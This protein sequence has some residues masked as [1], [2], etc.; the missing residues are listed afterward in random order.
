MLCE[1]AL[2]A[3]SACLTVAAPSTAPAP[4]VYASVPKPSIAPRTCELKFRYHDPQRV[5]VMLP[6]QSRPTVYWYMLYTIE[7]PGKREVGFYPHFEMVTDTLQVIPSEVSISPEAFRA[8]ARHSGNPLMVPP[9]QAVG[10]LLRGKDQ[11]RQSVAV[12]RDFEP[13]ARSFTIY[14]AGLSGESISVK[15]P[16]FQADKPESP[17]NK[18]YFLLRKTLAIPYVFPGTPEGH[19]QAMPQRLADKQEWILR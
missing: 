1:L 3:F 18:R 13:K 11:M 4:V 15:N 5:A 10:R 6:G 19:F 17:E 2:Q 7:N 12:W 16:A 8:I 14:V 9:E